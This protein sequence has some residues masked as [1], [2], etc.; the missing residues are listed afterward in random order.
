MKLGTETGSVMN[1]LESRMVIGEPKP[2][3]GM[4]V[5]MLGWT[6]RYPG[7]ITKVDEIAGS[8]VTLYIIE[9]TA[10]KYELVSGTTMD[11]SA[12][13]E[14][15]PNPDGYVEMFR[16]NKKTLMWEPVGRNENGR[17]VKR[18]GKGIVLGKR[19]RYYDPTF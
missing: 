15:S 8:K 18:E 5:T 7:T 6:D 3:V 11:G 1:Y 13:Y 19:E 10:D 14:Y 9:V 2:V 12:E 16:K 17:L 4:G